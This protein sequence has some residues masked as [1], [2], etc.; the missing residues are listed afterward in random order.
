M[1]IFA[2]PVVSVTDTNIFARL[3]PNS[4]QYLVY[5]MAFQTR[6]ANAII[7]PLPV[8]LPAGGKSLRFVSLKGYGDFFKDLSKGFPLAL[9]E[10]PVQSRSLGANKAERASKLIVHEVGDSIAS[11]VPTLADFDRLDRQFRVPRES[12]D[13]IPLYRDYG[14]A[15]FQLKS[16]KGKPHPM[17]FQFQSRLAQK[18]GGSIFFPTVHIHDGEVHKREKF[19]H[20]LFL[21]SSEFDKACG[22]YVKRGYLVTDKST[23]YV[24][25][26]WPAAEFCNIARTKG[27]V[28]GKALVHQLKMRGTLPNTDVLA[29]RNLSHKKKKAGFNPAAAAGLAGLIGAAAGMKWFCDRRN[30]VARE[31]ADV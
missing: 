30:Q 14:F 16:K 24:R 27:I 31:E 15:V 6:T 9:P 18:D 17:A 22:D 20:T 2:K 29:Y 5:Q 25:S 4:W 12:W 21:Q 1:C 13:K 28:D 7:L 19:D 10:S 11:F 3:L 26:K 23:G 8:A